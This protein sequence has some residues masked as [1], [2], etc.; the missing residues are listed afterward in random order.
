MKTDFTHFTH[1]GERYKYLESQSS[2]EDFLHHRVSDGYE[3]I[4]KEEFLRTVRYL[5]LAFYQK[6]WKGKQVAIG[7]DRQL[8]YRT[9]RS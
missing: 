4:S 8:P 6:G 1:F 9:T 3:N 5:A 7:V 2:K